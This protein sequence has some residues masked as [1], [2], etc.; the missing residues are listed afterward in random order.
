MVENQCECGSGQDYMGCCGQYHQDMASPLTTEALLRSRYCAYVREY[1]QY[2]NST[3]HS[4]TRPSDAIQHNP[5]LTWR[6][7]EVLTIDGG[8]EQDAKGNIEFIAH[9][10]IAG[11]PEELHERS[12]FVREAGRW[13]YVDGDDLVPTHV[14]ASGKIGRN[15]PCPCGSEKK[16]KKCCGVN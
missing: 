2:L 6:G 11:R 1:N 16:Y 7:L 10:T 15:D 9:Y 4:S 8:S 5:Q 14:T 12:H 13:F 3:W